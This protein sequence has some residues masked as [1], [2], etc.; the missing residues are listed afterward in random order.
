[1]VGL[2]DKLFEKKDRLLD[3]LS[4]RP[5]EFRRRH[6]KLRLETAVERNSVG[7]TAGLAYLHYAHFGMLVKETDGM[8]ETQLANKC[9]KSLIAAALRECSTD[10]LLR[11]S[12]DGDERLS[13]EIR[14]EEELL[15]LDEVAEIS[16][17]L[18]IRE[19]RV[20]S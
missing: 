17:K 15:T 2:K 12:G 7:K 5:P 10:T 14:I 9:G 19:C 11:E 16:K 1:M 4:L 20:E 8:V 6:P 3:S 18:G 13:L